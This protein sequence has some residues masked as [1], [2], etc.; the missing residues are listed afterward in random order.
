MMNVT[1]YTNQ[2]K[3]N[4]PD[5]GLKCDLTKTA[6]FR[7]I[8]AQ[9]DSSDDESSTSTSTVSSATTSAATAAS[10]VNTPPETLPVTSASPA[11]PTS[12]T[13]ASP[14]TQAPASPVNTP[15][16]TLPVNTPPET[17]PVQQPRIPV[18]HLH[19][20]YNPL[21][22]LVDQLTDEGEYVDMSNVDNDVFMG[23]INELE[24]DNEI[25]DILNVEVQPLE[26]PADMD[27]GIELGIADEDDE[28]NNLY[29]F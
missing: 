12:A 21:G 17:S 2:S 14:V 7:R 20:G 25:R 19:I 26:D 1:G 4:I 23:I 15:P 22:E 18:R 10:P 3:R 27:E 16:E 6:M 5:I 11:T 29:D 9:F 24:E 8:I 28:F 13:A